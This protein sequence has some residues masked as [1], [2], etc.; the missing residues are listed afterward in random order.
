M[1]QPTMRHLSGGHNVALAVTRS[2]E[3]GTYRHALA[4]NGITGH[5]F[6]ALKE[7]NV[8]QPLWLEPEGT[9]RRS[10][11]NILPAFATRVATMT[12]L[13]WDDCVEG[14]KQGALGAI[15]KPGPEQAVM[16][17]KRRERGE[18]GKSFGPRDLFDYI[19]AILHSPA[20]RDRYED[21]LKS[22]FAHIPVPTTGS[23]FEELVPLG[24]ELV[25]LHLLD[26]ETLPKLKD[27]KSVRLAGSGDALVTM[28]AARFEDDAYQDGRMYIAADRTR[29]FETVGPETVDFPIGGYLPARK[30]LKDRAP[31]GGKNAAPGRLLSNDDV[32]HYRRMIVALSRTA[33][34]MPKIDEVIEKHGGWPDAFRG[35]TDEPQA[36]AAE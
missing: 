33:E 30:W 6:V 21:D 10:I 14:P 12:K 23:L 36:E 13:A 2:L 9:E 11:P 17:R 19:Y 1:S 22:N 26:Y 3:G 29:W 35:M 28:P 32:L 20:Y 25:A 4:T 31:R 34:L 7:V 27:P 18:L 16:F 8:V 15:I 5:H 24:A